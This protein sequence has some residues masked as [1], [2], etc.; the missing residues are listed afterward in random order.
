MSRYEHAIVDY[1]NEKKAFTEMIRQ[2]DQDIAFIKTK[3]EETNTLWHQENLEKQKLEAV[4]DQQYR[5]AMELDTMR[6]KSD[7]D[8]N[9]YRTKNVQLKAEVGELIKENKRLATDK[10]NG[11]QRLNSLRQLNKQQIKKIDGLQVGRAQSK[12]DAS[13]NNGRLIEELESKLSFTV[14]KFEEQNMKF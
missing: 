5:E 9:F 11:A 14:Q 13:M 2:K 7:D 3:Y 4:V 6:R 10:V 12:I 1:E 8:K